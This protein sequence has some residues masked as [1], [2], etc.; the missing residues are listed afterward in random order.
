MT[1]H[2]FFLILI[3]S[4]EWPRFCPLLR[5]PRVPSRRPP[6]L[7][8]WKKEI[9]RKR[10][11]PK[12]SGLLRSRFLRL[13]FWLRFRFRG[14]HDDS[15]ASGPPGKDPSQVAVVRPSLVAPAAEAA[16]LPAIPA[17][18]FHGDGSG[19]V[20]GK[21]SLPLSLSFC[22]QISFSWFAY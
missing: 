8:P 4:M 10:Y 20:A 22:N 19:P 7:L 1:F 18:G 11:L 5:I 16:P 17:E 13:R 21:F 6:P 9:W 12:S 3:F 2:L 14:I 15:A